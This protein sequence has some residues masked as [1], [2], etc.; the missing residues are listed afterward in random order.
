MRYCF[1]V[2]SQLSFQKRTQDLGEGTKEAGRTT[3]RV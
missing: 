1:I 2:K 3:D